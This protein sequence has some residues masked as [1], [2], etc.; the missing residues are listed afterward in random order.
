MVPEKAVSAW[1]KPKTLLI[2]CV[3]SNVSDELVRETW[4]VASP[5]NVYCASGL[6]SIPTMFNVAPCD[7]IKEFPELIVNGYESWAVK[8]S[9]NINR[10]IMYLIIF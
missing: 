7:M 8:K 10:E 3:L 2:V 9:G 6:N 5:L 1:S 4:L